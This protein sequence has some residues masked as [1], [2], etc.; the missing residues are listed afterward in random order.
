MFGLKIHY[1]MNFLATYLTC[2]IFMIVHFLD[3]V[4]RENLQIRNGI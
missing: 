1:S 4:A 3:I 2:D